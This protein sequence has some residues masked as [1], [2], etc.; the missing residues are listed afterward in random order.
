MPKSLRLVV[1]FDD[2]IALNA[3]P[4]ITGLVPEAKESLVLLHNAGHHITIWS[5][6][7]SRVIHSET[8]R[9]LALQNMKAYLDSNGIPYDVIDYGTEGKPVGVYCDNRA[10]GAPTVLYKGRLVFN[11]K[12]AYPMLRLLA[13]SSKY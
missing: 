2:T 9:A 10:L 13:I 7:N 6:R 4:D 1:D 8:V 11:W 5:A 3:W 12:K